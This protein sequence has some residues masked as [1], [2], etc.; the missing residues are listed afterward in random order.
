MF[1]MCNGRHFHKTLRTRRT[2]HWTAG[3]P[4]AGPLAWFKGVREEAS[5]RHTTSNCLCASGGGD[6]ANKYFPDADVTRT[7]DT[8]RLA[9]V[10]PA[11]PRRALRQ[12]SRGQ[13][14]ENQARTLVLLGPGRWDRGA[15]PFRDGTVQARLRKGNSSA[16]TYRRGPNGHEPDCGCRTGR[17][18]P[19]RHLQR[20]S[21]KAQ[22]PRGARRPDAE[23]RTCDMV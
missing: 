1:V 9:G 7:G 22:S 6:L 18:R 4:R 23:E 12:R 14:Q 3:S 19:G 15:C 5:Q 20:G 11:R 21:E 2:C 16:H 10:S 13:L 17:G 8:A